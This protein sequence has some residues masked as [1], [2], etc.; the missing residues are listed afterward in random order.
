MTSPATIGDHDKGHR[1]GPVCILY[2]DDDGAA[3]ETVRSALDD[4][5]DRYELVA[6]QTGTDAMAKVESGNVDCIVSEYA[7]EGTNGIE[8]L[9]QVREQWPDLPFILFT[10]D[11]SEAVAREAI[12][13]DV[14]AYLRKT[15]LDEQASALADRVVEAVTVK[16]EQAAIFGRMTDAFFAV[17]DDWQFTYLNERG[18]EMVCE[19]IGTEA[20][21]GELLGQN[22]WEA[23][24]EAVGTEFY[25]QYHR[26]MAE[27]EAVSF[28]AYYEPVSK[29]LEVRAYPSPTGLS[30]YFR[31]V[32]ERHEREES[33]AER[34]R[35][36]KEVYRVIAEKETTF[37]A[38]VE[39]LLDIG[40]AVLGTDCAALSHIDGEDY[41]FEIVKDP[42]GGADPGD[43]VPLSAT[44]CERA[45]VEE[46]TLVLS[47]IAS[48][49]P[50]LTDR[51]GF[52]EM[53]ISCYL[54][55][56][57]VV[58]GEVYGTFCFY[59]RTP[60]PEPFS[61]WEVTLV[62]LMGNW[63]S[64]EQER[65]RREAELT[66]ERN[67]LDDFASLV[68]HDLRNP[69]GV[70]MGRLDL[71]REGYDGDPEH[72]DAVD[73]SLDRMD[74]IIDDMLTLARLGEQVADPTACAL[75]ELASEAWASVETER[76]TLEVTDGTMTIEGDHG[77]LR[78][79]FENLFRNAVE[80]GSTSSRP[81]ADDAVENGST[82]PASKARQDAVE[83]GGS[84]V[85]VSVGPIPGED[86]FYVEDDGPGISPE[87]RTKV[88]ESGYT[89]S[90]AGTGFGLRIVTEIVEAHGGEIT[91][92]ESDK[93]GARFEVTGIGGS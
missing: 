20:S 60:R 65:Q 34:E 69:L 44:N 17:D 3:N 41:I 43:V 74:E 57:L 51:A 66:R 8:L 91:V 38:K 63:V 26:A 52:T 7:L 1:S 46:R 58:D 9:R 24:P 18:R 54:G 15:P 47:D 49:A 45:V 59:D 82:S 88:F 83:H 76:A 48:D 30:V 31:D 33:L 86:G 19:A 40:Q 50:E 21:I 84:N 79:L 89:T 36:L 10:D 78:Q 61:D 4:E 90:E 32:T 37:E 64:Y 5:D 56:P 29:W 71:V 80:H 93:G 25:D 62:E 77:R 12:A 6:T 72:L 92:T 55:T 22:I 70:A 75:G 85:T 11:G 28:D 73:R 13:A 68:S 67:R 16:S 2:V 53:G 39:Q 81:T 42:D 87:E 35:V 14:T 27:Q 23:A